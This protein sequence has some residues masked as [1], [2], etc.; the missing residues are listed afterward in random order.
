MILSC[1]NI[2]KSFGERTL[3]DGISFH[4]EEREKAEASSTNSKTK[5]TKTVTK[6]KKTKTQVSSMKS[7]PRKSKISKFWI[8]VG[9]SFIIS[10]FM[11]I[12]I[13]L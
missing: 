2:S 7:V 12:F 11:M 8:V 6:P 9:V 3:L 5:K 10:L 1:Q 13:L 4:I